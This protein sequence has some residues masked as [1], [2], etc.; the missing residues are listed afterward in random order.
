M[1]TLKF[2]AALG[3]S[4]SMVATDSAINYAINVP[5]SNGIL[6]LEDS[7]TGA[8]YIASGTTAQR[9]A[10]PVYGMIRYNSTLGYP[11][12]YNGTSWVLL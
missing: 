4:V 6:L 1:S 8:A 3:G 7:A 9:P 11:E 2:D 10:S 5:T 12:W